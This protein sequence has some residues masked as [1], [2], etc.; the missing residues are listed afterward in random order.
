[1]DSSKKEH[2]RLRQERAL[3]KEKSALLAVLFGGEKDLGEIRGGKFS[4]WRLEQLSF[5]PEAK[6][7]AVDDCVAAY[8]ERKAAYEQENRGLF[9]AEWRAQ[10]HQ[11]EVDLMEQL[12]HLLTS[13]ELREYELRNSQLAE[14][15][16]GNLEHV[17]LTR[18]QY[19]KLFDTYKKYGDMNNWIADSPE[20]SEKAEEK[21]KA[22]MAELRATL[23]PAVVQEYE[24]NQDGDYTVLKT[25][26]KRN[27]LPQE[28]AD[29]VYDLKDAAESAVE[30]IGQNGQLT[31]DQRDQALDAIRSE[32]EK[33]VQGTLGDA[34]YKKYLRSGGW[35]INELAPGPSSR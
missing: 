23:G 13:A 18:E 24:R 30:H 7:E 33:V 12:S 21:E 4:D 32:T 31:P 26:A 35:W 10:S 2:E 19:E 28:T 8:E 29:K 17:S 5:L 25:M 16:S 34:L 20:E 15:L 27:N 22:L 14:E 9:D 11:F 3:L 6:R 1:L